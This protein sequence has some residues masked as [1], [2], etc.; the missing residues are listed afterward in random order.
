MIKFGDYEYG[1]YI[2]RQGLTVLPWLAWDSI[3]TGLATD[4]QRSACFCLQN[5]GTKGIYYPQDLVSVLA[6]I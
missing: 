3:E 6:L 5:T 2:L 1:K 4:S